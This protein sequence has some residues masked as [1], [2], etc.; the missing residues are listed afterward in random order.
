LKKDCWLLG[1]G[2][3]AMFVRFVAGTDV[4]NAFRL[5]GVITA[6]WTLRGKGELYDH[7][8]KWLD[9][10][11]IWFN[12]HL[13][14]P[15]FRRKLRSGE[16]TRDAVCWFRDDAGEPLRRIWD[17]VALVKEHGTTVRLITT[18]KPGKIVYADKYQVV[19]ETPYWALR[20]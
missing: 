20:G 15:P 13:P 3:F 11:I 12:E 14:C 7:E 18:D 1:G 19:A 17:L 2:L 9:E 16:W 6:A 10:V 5:D 8:S 4:D